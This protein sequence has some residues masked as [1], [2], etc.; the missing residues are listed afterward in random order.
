MARPA[1]EGKESRPAVRGLVQRIRALF[2][3]RDAAGEQI[4]RER[5]RAKIR[6][7]LADMIVEIDVDSYPEDLRPTESTD[8]EAVFRSLPPLDPPLS[9][10]II[11]EREEQRY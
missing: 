11:Q 6:A 7:A 1:I 8:R 2:A 10:A 5:E 3:R 4:Q 9:A